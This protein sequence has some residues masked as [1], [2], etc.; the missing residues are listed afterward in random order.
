MTMRH[1]FI[2]LSTLFI[3]LVMAVPVSAQK[4]YEVTASKLNVRSEAK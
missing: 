4:T 2:L 1:F 3:A